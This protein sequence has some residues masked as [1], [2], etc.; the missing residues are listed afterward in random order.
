MI[1]C[2]LCI[3]F[4]QHSVK[5]LTVSSRRSIVRCMQLEKVI[6]LK[7][8]PSDIRPSC[9]KMLFTSVHWE[10][11]AVLDRPTG[12]RSKREAR[13]VFPGFTNRDTASLGRRPQISWLNEHLR[14]AGKDQKWSFGRMVDPLYWSRSFYFFFLFFFLFQIY[15]YRVA[16]S[17]IHCST[18]GPC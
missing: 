10:T 1:F 15:L 12:W 14:V 16:H 13:T 8:S 6:S 9:V 2:V 4:E 11:I 5:K 3:C 17:V 7:I 18:T